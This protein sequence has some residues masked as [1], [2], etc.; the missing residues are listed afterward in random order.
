MARLALLAAFALL[1]QP[2]A[3]TF[4]ESRK[5]WSSEPGLMDALFMA[6]IG[7]SREFQRSLTDPWPMER[8]ATD[9][10]F[11]LFDGLQDYIM[12][13]GA[14]PKAVL[15]LGDVAYGG[16]DASVCEQTQE[17]FQKY[18]FGQVPRTMVFPVI[19]NHDVNY[20]GCTSLEGV[21]SQNSNGTLFLGEEEQS[22]V[23]EEAGFSQSLYWEHDAPTCH[24]GTST[25]LYKSQPQM[26]FADWRQNWMTS[27]PGL[28]DM[29]IKFQ[30]DLFASSSEWLPPLRYNIELDHRSS[31]Y[32]IVGLISGATALQ[33]NG[34]TPLDSTDGMSAD[35]AGLECRYLRDSLAEGRRR[36]KTIFIYLTHHFNKAC[37]D[38]S[39]IQQ[40]DVWIYGHVHSFWQSVDPGSI[41]VQE[42]RHFP[43]RILIGNGGFD[44]GMI[45]FVSFG[46]LREEVV[47]VE[48]DERVRVHFDMKQ[49]CISAEESCTRHQNGGNSLRKCWS[50]CQQNSGLAKHDAN[51]GFV[52]EAPRRASSSKDVDSGARDSPLPPVLS[53]SAWKLFLT[54][55][56]ASDGTTHLWL[57][58]TDCPETEQSASA[59]SDVA[60]E[61]CISVTSDSG[62]AMQVYF[63]G[64]QEE[65]SR[66]STA[67]RRFSAQM[68]VD[69]N[70]RGPVFMGSGNLLRRSGSFWSARNNV[71]GITPSN[72]FRFSFT[73]TVN[74]SS[75]GSIGDWKIVGSD[76]T[77]PSKSEQP[78]LSTFGL[79]S[80]GIAFQD[81]SGTENSW[82]EHH[83]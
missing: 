5:T 19:G 28:D 41:L 83:A 63:Y 3:Q 81:T 51:A 4:L 38:W 11:S 21:W 66:S 71:E 1:S 68:A 45:N 31:I 76:W 75:E 24:Y 52:L 25:K 53:R 42:R 80:I 55:T 10:S 62:S 67:T 7:H 36:G 8:T 56:A 23:F 79:G 40:L 43:A 27:F 65:S 74:A 69:D 12:S 70:V 2:E 59:E 15:V 50:K 33:W 73:A 58:L 82:T 47:K 22:L 26:S 35:A 16:G 57:S 64:G 72:A 39:L 37:D 20:L 34:D 30:R 14:R 32:L 6:D 60:E 18:L 77:M 48:G 78:L 13:Q 54:D 29:V 9:G 49:T 61:K 44:Q 17:S 46:H